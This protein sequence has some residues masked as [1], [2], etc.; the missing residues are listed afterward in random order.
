MKSQ[1]KP[2]EF[3]KGDWRIVKMHAKIFNLCPGVEPTSLGSKDEA[4]PLINELDNVTFPILHKCYALISFSFCNALHV[5]MPPLRK[6]VGQQE[7]SISLINCESQTE[8]LFQPARVTSCFHFSP[9]FHIKNRI[10]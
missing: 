10:R 7:L 3:K 4:M 1:C 6:G 5:R 8:K 2:R 9:N